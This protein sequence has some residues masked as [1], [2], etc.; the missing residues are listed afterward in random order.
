MLSNTVPVVL[1]A[2]GGYLLGSR[3]QASQKDNSKDITSLQSKLDD[4]ISKIENGAKQV[5]L[6]KELDVFIS[7]FEKAKREND[8]LVSQLAALNVDD[9]KYLPSNMNF[10]TAEIIAPKIAYEK[11]KD[12]S[13]FVADDGY[14][15]ATF[16]PSFP[17]TTIECVNSS[18]AGF[19]AGGAN[20]Q[21]DL[22]ML[23]DKWLYFGI[24]QA[25]TQVVPSSR[26]TVDN[27]DEK[28]ETYLF[29][30]SRSFSAREFFD[31]VEIRVGLGTTKALVDGIITV[32]PYR[33]NVFAVTVNTQ[34]RA[35]NGYGIYFRS[36]FRDTTFPVESISI[37]KSRISSER[38]LESIVPYSLFPGQAAYI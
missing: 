15:R 16:C 31:S 22:P 25:A 24:N 34:G 38:A 10:S 23:K 27:P 12:P 19:V 37:I 36:R 21:R 29:H 9:V 2:A 28:V 30:M 20:I 13:F 26:W 11:S 8:Q 33:S 14:I 4:I 1:A 18:G 32:I 5:D 7:L 17:G 6:V 3:N 35:G